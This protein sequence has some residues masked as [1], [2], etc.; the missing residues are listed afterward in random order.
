MIRMLARNTRYPFQR[1]WVEFDIGNFA[2]F[3]FLDDESIALDI[4]ELNRELVRNPQG[5]IKADIPH[6]GQL[7]TKLSFEQ[8]ADKLNGV[9]I[10]NRLN[11]RHGHV[12]LLL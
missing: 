10:F 8:I 11:F 2:G 4:T 12:P 6:I 7:L 9:L 3:R 1:L 5:E